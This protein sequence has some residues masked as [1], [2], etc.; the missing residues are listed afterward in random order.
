MRCEF[1][2]A[3][4]CRKTE[5]KYKQKQQQQRARKKIEEIKI[6]VFGF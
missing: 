5:M 3:Q 6:T 1:T 4:A 2:V